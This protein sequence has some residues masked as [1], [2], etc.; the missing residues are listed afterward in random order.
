VRAP[1]RGRRHKGRRQRG[2]SYPIRIREG[3]E[4]KREFRDSGK[5]KWCRPEGFLATSIRNPVHTYVGEA[6]SKRGVTMDWDGLER[7]L[8]QT[9]PAIRAA[10]Q[11]AADQMDRVRAVLAGREAPVD[12]EDISVVVFGSLARGEWTTGS[13]LDWTLLIDGQ[14]DHRHALTA[15]D[16]GDAFQVGH[17]KGPGPTGVFGSMAFSHTLIHQI[18]GDDDTNQNTTRRLLLLLES[19]PV[20]RPDAYDRVL[21]GILSR[22]LQNDFRSFRVGIPYFL[23]NDLHRFWRTMCVDYAFKNR[24]RFGSGWALRVIKLRLSRKLIFVAGLLTCLLCDRALLSAGQLKELEDRGVSGLV[25]YLLAFLRRPPLDTLADCLVRFATPDTARKVLG[26]YNEFLDRLNDGQVR[27]TLE[28]LR[29]LVDEGN[30]VLAEL[31]AIGHRFQDG[32]IDL[33]FH[34]HEELAKLTRYYGI[35]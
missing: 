11:R 30:P 19:R 15:Q 8:G 21:Q 6:G 27:Q 9:W 12:S 2:P 29:P 16:V 7:Q 17:F 1:G 4:S 35:F 13:D 18:G 20:N 24:E 3:V 23:L 34:G 31:K 33:F 5:K 10:R 22:Y 28:G 26:A 14:A 32:L 25:D